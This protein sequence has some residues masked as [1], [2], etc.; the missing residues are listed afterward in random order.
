MESHALAGVE[1]ASRAAAAALAAIASLATSR[2]AASISVARLESCRCEVA[3]AENREQRN[4]RF[5][6]VDVSAD[7]IEA[8]VRHARIP[9]EGA[10]VYVWNTASARHGRLFLVFPE[11]QLIRSVIIDVEGACGVDQLVF[12]SG[13]SIQQVAKALRFSLG[14]SCVESS[15]ESAAMIRLSS[16]SVGDDAFVSVRMLDLQPGPVWSGGVF[17]ADSRNENLPGVMAASFDGVT[18]DAHGQDLEATIIV[19][20]WPNLEFIPARGEAASLRIRNRS[21]VADIDLTV[22]EPLG[23]GNAQSSAESFFPYYVFR[24]R[25][26]E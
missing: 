26:G 17:H 11:P 19:G 4:A 21:L 6:I 10:D 20:D 16:Q 14:R 3:A 12:V 2:E 5:E 23:Y 24:L 15:L 25:P 1:R 8:A 7:V 22:G 18:V 9:D 13:T